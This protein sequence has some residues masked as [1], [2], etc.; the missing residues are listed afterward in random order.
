MRALLNAGLLMLIPVSG[1]A[2]QQAVEPAA[3]LES[4]AWLAGCWSAVSPDGQNAAEEQWMAPRG[5][6]MVGMA[7]TVRGGTARGHELL[8]LRVGAD[9]GLI[10]RAA[11]SGQAVTDFA[12]RSIRPGQLEFSNPEHDFP[13]RIVYTRTAEDV[14][15]VAV[16]GHVDDTE[17]AFTL[18]YRRVACTGS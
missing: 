6:L 13:Q 15:D 10:Y 1:L 18:P 2:A 9:G 3:A 14:A 5:G 17:P 4:A 16:F 8:T 11:P 7:R 12:G